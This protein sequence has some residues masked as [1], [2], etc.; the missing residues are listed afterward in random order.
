MRLSRQLYYFQLH[1]QY[2]KTFY[3]PLE[4]STAQ[5]RSVQDER[6]TTRTFENDVITSRPPDRPNRNAS[7]PPKVL[8]TEFGRDR[9]TGESRRI[10]RHASPRSSR[11]TSPSSHG[12]KP[13]RLTQP[14]DEA[15]GTYASYDDA[16]RKPRRQLSPERKWDMGLRPPRDPLCPTWIDYREDGHSR[17]RQRDDQSH[18]WRRSR[19]D[20]RAS[21]VYVHS[22]VRSREQR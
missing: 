1:R 21:S 14:N 11:E 9:S 15:I 20:S 2:A 6:A 10:I 16:L 7:L 4:F 17:G 8:V 22:F 3:K 19:S 5:A 18:D 12:G 13:Q